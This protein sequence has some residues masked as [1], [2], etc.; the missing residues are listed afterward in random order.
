MAHKAERLLGSTLAGN[1]PP[2]APAKTATGKT[3][4]SV[5][6]P[7]AITSIWVSVGDGI[8]TKVLNAIKKMIV[9]WLKSVKNE[10]WIAP[11][12]YQGIPRTAALP[13]AKLFRPVVQCIEPDTNFLQRK[14]EVTDLHF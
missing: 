14:Q 5:K 10:V 12:G 1:A 7:T 11:D 9:F 3:A 8:L 2:G 13:L 4:D 6:T